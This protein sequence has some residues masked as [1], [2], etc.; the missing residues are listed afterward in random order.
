MCSH[1]RLE[2]FIGTLAEER[3]I[4]AAA[5]NLTDVSYGSDSVLCYHIPKT[6][7]PPNCRR[8]NH[9]ADDLRVCRRESTLHEAPIR[10]R[11]DRIETIVAFSIIK[12]NIRI[13][14]FLIII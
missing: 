3:L 4:E 7:P 6:I 8:N 11:I 2:K 10:Y 5:R 12:N 14:L 9:R 13:S 1:Y